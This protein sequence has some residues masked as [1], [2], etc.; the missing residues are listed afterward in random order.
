MNNLNSL[1]IEGNLTKDPKLTITPGE[2]SV[3]DLSIAV[4]RYYKKDKE[5]Q[6]ETSYFDVQIWNGLADSCSLHLSKGRGIRVTG[7]LKQDTW[8]DKDTGENRYK[9]YIVAEHVDFKPHFIN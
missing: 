9:V 2:K 5:Q 7:R 8:I 4:N 6:K 3:C 1:L